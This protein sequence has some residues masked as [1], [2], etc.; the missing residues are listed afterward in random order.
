MLLVPNYLNIISL[1]ISVLLIDFLCIFFVCIFNL[2]F[3]LIIKII[4]TFQ[5]KSLYLNYLNYFTM[6]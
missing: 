2:L 5:I 6:F 4:N 3:Y 1:F